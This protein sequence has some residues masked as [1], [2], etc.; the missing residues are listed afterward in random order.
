MP[1]APKAE[2]IG[3]GRSTLPQ[4][5]ARAASAGRSGVRAALDSSP[6]RWGLLVIVSLVLSAL[7]LAWPS[8]PTTDPW[9]W[10]VWG[11]E[12]AALRLDTSGGGAPSWKPLPV[13]FTA[14]LS[15]LGQAAPELWLLLARAGGLLA[16]ALAYRTA[17]RLAGVG[18]GVLAAALLLLSAGWLRGHLHGYLEPTLVAVLL[19][20]VELHAARRGRAVVGL[21]FLAGLIRPEAWP[22]LGI[23]GLWRLRVAPAE[24]K[25]VAGVL[26][27]TPLLWFGGDLWGSG[28]ALHGGE[29]ASAIADRTGAS[30]LEL[31]ALA[32]NKLE[33]MVIGL[34]LVGGWWAGRRGDRLGVALAAGS[35]A[36]AALLV[37]LVAVGY[38]ASPRFA[39]PPLAGACVLGGAGAGFLWR[40]VA[41]GSALRVA[42][43]AGG[44]AI[45][46]TLVVS[47]I[48]ASLA[49][50]EAASDRAELQLDLRD[51]I[52]RVGSSRVLACGTP[53]LDGQVGWNEG[54]LAWELGLSLSELH[55]GSSSEAAEMGERRLIAVI[56]T[57]DRPVGPASLVRSRH[58]TV[59]CLAPDRPGVGRL[60][61]A[62]L[63]KSH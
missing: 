29:K 20:A 15:V 58:W 12:V 42:V 45:A 44:A 27:A 21:L 53:V 46:A 10:I 43:L 40:G 28:D 19:G 49:S 13:L 30:G 55:V 50:V 60:G 62:R 56:T 37:A 38:P 23:Y 25:L 59:L 35:L 6:R 11:R 57:R 39:A 61:P 41:T 3:R 47:R 4:D 2:R 51:A 34:A 26:L 31:L 5:E 18:A 22:V 14:P 16:L 36:W 9:G 48:D 52:D 7:S 33:L 54:A 8:V 17:A 63:G 1:A 32:V 24:R